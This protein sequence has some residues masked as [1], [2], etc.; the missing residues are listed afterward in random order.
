V[1]ATWDAQK[2]EALQQTIPAKGNKKKDGKCRQSPVFLERSKKK[3]VKKKK[4]K[5]IAAKG[6]TQKKSGPQ[7]RGES[8]VAKKPK[9]KGDKKGVP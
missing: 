4:T 2:K 6:E 8:I 9:N 7:L 3:K 5:T 1:S